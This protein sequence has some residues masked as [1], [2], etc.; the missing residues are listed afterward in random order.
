LAET[1]GIT[2]RLE[3][4][5]G[6]YDL[7]FRVLTDNR[8][9]HV[10]KV[11][12]P[13][14]DLGLV[15][16]QCAAL[17]HLAHTAPAVPLPRVVP[18]LDGASVVTRD[19]PDGQPRLAWL[20]TSLDGVA[21]G[22]FRPHRPALL[23]ELGRR[24]GELDAGLADFAHPGL[25]RSFKWNLTGSGWIRP[26]L[27]LI[28]EPRRRIVTCICDEFDARLAPALAGL[29]CAPIH[30]D[31]NDYNI[32]VARDASGRA[33]ISGLIDFGDMAA[34]P[35]VCEVA[36]AGAYAVLDQER[37]LDALAALVAGYDAVHPLTD[38][39]LALVWPLLLTRLAVSV[40]NAAMMKRERP[41][42][43]RGYRDLARCLS[44]MGESTAAEAQERIAAFI[45]GGGS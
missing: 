23:G 10:M 19:G 39:E 8:P 4:L 9:S 24:I 26:H 44:M 25:T 36:I 16:M 34:A 11:M 20:I 38:D 31:I 29:P 1:H 45:D 30:N 14:C 6:E 33:R 35:A 12:R 42:D 43:P 18:A 21:Y 40:V 17:A 3:T 5:D 2:A 28:D 15:E 22:N 7:N 41:D 37:P 32:L 27:G 13:G